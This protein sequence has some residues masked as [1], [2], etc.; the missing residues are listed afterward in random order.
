MLLLDSHYEESGT[1]ASLPELRKT[2]DLAKPT[3]G[4]LVNARLNR[5][6][7][8]AALLPT[9]RDNDV[10]FLAVEMPE[11]NDLTV[12]IMALVA[13]Q[14]PSTPTACAPR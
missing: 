9:L 2:L 1:L 14:E 6:N 8:N 3:G 10:R 4:I 12:S 5:L 13:Q 11:A 7:R